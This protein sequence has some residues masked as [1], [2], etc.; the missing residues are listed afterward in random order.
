MGKSEEGRLCVPFRGRKNQ[1]SSETLK[2]ETDCIEEEQEINL[3]LIV[4]GFR[5]QGEE[6]R[7]CEW[8]TNTVWDPEPWVPWRCSVCRMS[9]IGACVRDQNCSCRCRRCRS[10]D[11]HQHL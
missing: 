5:R 2:T 11:S 7:L 6:C 4:Q 10:G 8:E 3:G 9:G 1:G